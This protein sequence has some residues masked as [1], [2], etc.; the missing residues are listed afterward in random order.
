[1][2]SIDSKKPSILSSS[3]KQILKY[4][5]NNSK[6]DLGERIFRRVADKNGVFQEYFEG[7]PKPERAELTEGLR[8]GISNLFLIPPLFRQ[9]IVK[10]V[11][12]ACGTEEGLEPVCKDFGGQYAQLDFKPDFVKIANSLTTECVF[13]DAAV[14]NYTETLAAWY[15]FI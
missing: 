5:I 12:Q 1:M 8:F 3:Q 2:S 13:L 15:L 14:H 4:C 6:E 9:F 7:L 11:D 10:I